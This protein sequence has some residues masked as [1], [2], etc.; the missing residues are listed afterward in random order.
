MCVFKADFEDEEMEVFFA[1]NDDEAMKIA[2][3]FEEDHGIL[4]NVFEIDQNYDEI[5]TLI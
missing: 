3:S 5:R 4:F 2:F 1:K